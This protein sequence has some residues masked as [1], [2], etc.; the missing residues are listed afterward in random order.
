[1]VL[2]GSGLGLAPR[3]NIYG[4]RFIVRGGGGMFRLI[5]NLMFKF[6]DS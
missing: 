2:M 4:V 1:M 6:M 3:Y 5:L